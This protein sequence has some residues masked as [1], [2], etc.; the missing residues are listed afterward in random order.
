MN[1]IIS[2]WMKRGFG[3]LIPV[4]F[5]I[6]GCANSQQEMVAK[7]QLERAR[8]AYMQAKSNRNVEAFAP[9]PLSTPAK[10]C[11]PRSRPGCGRGGAVELYRREKVAHRHLRS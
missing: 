9:C 4:L 5:L 2:R 3:L 10:P 1:H 7:D 6:A 8:S 11:R